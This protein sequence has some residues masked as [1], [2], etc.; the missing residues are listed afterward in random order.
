[1][2]VIRVVS[3]PEVPVTDVPVTVVA[4]TIAVKPVTVEV[5]AT[6]AAEGDPVATEAM[7][8]TEAVATEMEAMATTSEPMAAASMA[9][10]AAATT[11]AAGV[12]DLGQRDDHGDQQSKHQIEQL[13]TYDTHSFCRRS[14]PSTLPYTCSDDGEAAAMP[15][16]F[17]A[18][19]FLL[20]RPPAPRSRHDGIAAITVLDH[21]P[22]GAFA[23]RR[24]RRL[25][26][27]AQ[28]RPALNAWAGPILLCR[29]GAGH[30][31]RCN[32]ERRK[33]ED[34]YAH[35]LVLA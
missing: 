20:R 11:S 25:D 24:P 8:T 26:L 15:V 29:R 5:T 31:G 9:S 7:E 32:G 21:M 34:P 3:V 6:K 27:D 35:W 30:P 23:D 18:V 2:V 22:I 12:G 33:P 19:E 13:T 16:V 28:R 1:M 17:I 10:T 14:S 4:I